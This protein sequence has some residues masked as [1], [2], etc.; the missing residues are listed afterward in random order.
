VTL[1]PKSAIAPELVFDVHEFDHPVFDHEV[2]ASQARIQAM[3][4]ARN[5]WFC[6][7]HLRHGFHEDGLASAVYVTRL[8]GAKAPWR[9]GALP[10][11]AV[12]TR[13]AGLRSTL[14][15]LLAGTEAA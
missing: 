6:G 8:L 9:A 5:T 2:V 12:A 7:A 11:S 10:D 14:G 15:T 13:P 1:T 4:G 3:Q